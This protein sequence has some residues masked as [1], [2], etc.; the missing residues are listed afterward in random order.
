MVS[1]R[2]ERIHLLDITAIVSAFVI[3]S[4]FEAV[5]LFTMFSTMGHAGPEGRF[6]LLG[7]LSLAMN[8]PGLWLAGFLRLPEDA[9]S[10]RI[11][12]AIYGLQ[13]PVV[14]Y[15]IFVVLRFLK[16][17]LHNKTPGN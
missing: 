5:T 1:T 2:R 7:W 6:A 17:R 9:S 10:L 3:A 4:L 11:A 12:I 16:T 15:L 8:L 13:I 14:W